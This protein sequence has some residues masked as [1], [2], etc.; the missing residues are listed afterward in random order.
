M[1]SLNDL[2][3]DISV[4]KYI[5]RLIDKPQLMWCLDY[6]DGPLSGICCYNG[7][8]HH[9]DMVKEFVYNEEDE[10]GELDTCFCRVYAVIKLTNIQR[11]IEIYNHK[12][13]QKYV[14]HHTDYDESGHRKLPWKPTDSKFKQLLMRVP[15]LGKFIKHN[16]RIFYQKIRA[17]LK[18]IDVS[19]NDV[20]AWWAEKEF[21]INYIIE[22]PDVYTS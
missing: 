12:V 1:I 13:F 8:E 17:T 3:K 5:P 6:W 22:V 11:A 14:G 4:L 7:D 18:T 10:D 16:H 2:N 21:D 20:V 9:F 15:I 19:N